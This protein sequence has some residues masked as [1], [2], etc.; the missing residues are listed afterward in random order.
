MAFLQSQYASGPNLQF[1]TDDKSGLQAA[2]GAKWKLG[3]PYTIVIAPDGTKV[4]YEKE[5]K[6]DLLALRRAVLANMADTRGYPGN[7]AYWAGK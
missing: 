3:A 5:G 4:L 7:Q 1:A 6:I 2:F